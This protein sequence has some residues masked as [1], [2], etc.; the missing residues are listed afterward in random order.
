MMEQNERDTIE[1]NMHSL[2]VQKQT[3]QQQISETDLALKELQGATTAYRLVGGLM[4]QAP[5]ENLSE[6]LTKKKEAS[7]ARLALIEKQQERLKSKIEEK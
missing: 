3:V 2:A 6:E 1:Q 4:V 7:Q 5:V